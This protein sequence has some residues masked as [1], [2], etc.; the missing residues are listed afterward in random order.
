MRR[1]LART[2]SVARSLTTSCGARPNAAARHETPAQTFDREADWFGRQ[3]R[4][5]PDSGPRCS[6]A[7][8]CR[9]PGDT[10]S[11]TK[12]PQGL[13]QASD[14]YNQ[15]YAKNPSLLSKHVDDASMNFYEAMRFGQQV[16]GFDK[17]TAAVNALE[18]NK[19]PTKFES[20]YW[21]QKF[22]DVTAAVKS[23]NTGWFSGAPENAARSLRRSND[24]EVLLQAGATRRPLSKR[25]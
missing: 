3:R 23:A 20:Q 6:S 25:L 2:K 4:R 5:E 17:R 13:D 21:K 9:A 16:A 18:V 7:A 8:T 14:L 11:G 1:R 15:L 24:C 12:L 22:D 10:V 19:D